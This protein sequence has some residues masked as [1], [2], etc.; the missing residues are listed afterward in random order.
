MIIKNIS[1][2]EE[3]YMEQK[4]EILNQ[5]EKCNIKA[6]IFYRDEIR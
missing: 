3:R 2:L 1:N 5:K 4:I 6:K